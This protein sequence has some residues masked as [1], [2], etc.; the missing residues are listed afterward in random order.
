LTLKDL[1]E[2]NHP[3]TEQFKKAELPMV[4]VS[5]T[6]LERTDGQAIMNFVNKLAENTNVI[7]K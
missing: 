5:I 7:N 4:I 6:A 2:G 1:A 3:F